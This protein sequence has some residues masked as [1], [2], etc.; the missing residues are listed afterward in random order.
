MSYQRLFVLFV[1]VSTGAHAQWLNFPTPERP[2]R[3]TA[4]PT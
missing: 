4:N 2:A 3:M 1:L